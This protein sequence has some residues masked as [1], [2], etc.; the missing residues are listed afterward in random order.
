[1]IT[2]ENKPPATGGPN[3]SASTFGSALRSERERLGLTQRELADRLE[4]SQQNVAGWEGG[5]AHPGERFH[6]RMLQVFGEH[7]VLGYLQPKHRFAPPPDFEPSGFGAEA[8]L[9]TDEPVPVGPPLTEE[10]PPPLR[11]FAHAQVGRWDVDYLSDRICA[12]IKLLGSHRLDVVCRVGMQQLC[13]LRRALEAGS[14]K[15]RNSERVFLLVLLVSNLEAAVTDVALPHL[16]V[17][18]GALGIDIQLAPNLRSAASIIE[19]LETHDARAHVTEDFG[20]F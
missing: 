2:L 14:D 13:V 8:G 7:S 3:A 10:L 15:P 5:K 19:R 18:G 12:E 6:R 16:Y 9:V 17:E 20:L 4:T 11:R 1:M